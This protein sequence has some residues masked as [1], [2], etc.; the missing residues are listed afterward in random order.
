MNELKLNLNKETADRFSV[1]LQSEIYLK[2]QN[3][4]E[5]W[6][7][8][9][10]GNIEAF[11]VDGNNVSIFLWNSGLTDHYPQ[12]FGYSASS[13]SIK[14][15]IRKKVLNRLGY[16][17]SPAYNPL[18]HFN[19]NWPLGRGG[20]ISAKDIIEEYGEI[21][22]YGITK[23]C[24]FY[25]EIHEV[26]QISGISFNRVLEIGPGPANLLRMV[27]KYQPTST[28]IIVDLPTSLPYSFCNLLHRFPDA[29][30]CMPH[31]ATS[32]MDL[33]AIDFLFLTNDQTKIIKENSIDLAINTMSFQ[34]MKLGDINFYFSWLR[35]VMRKENLFYCMNA[36][37]KPMVFDGK[38]VPIRFHEYPWL[39]KD[40]I[41]KYELSPIE[42]GRTYKPFYVKATKMAVCD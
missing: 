26:V 8:R 22:D 25:N 17:S 2:E 6:G 12:N 10:Q 38:T 34:E 15:Y 16:Y 30:F 9:Q 32:G 27:K 39:D 20:E 36:V 21:D 11:K 23:G 28:I 41:Y 18:H 24:Y 31:E 3:L 14:Q 5:H 4:T 29:N 19:Q 35:K 40:K 7:K 33:D 13:R 37:E 42:H 1:Y